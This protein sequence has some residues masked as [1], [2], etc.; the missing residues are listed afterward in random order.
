MTEQD[1]IITAKELCDAFKNDRMSA[2]KGYLN[3]TITVKGIV[4]Y[5]GP[6]EYTLPSVELSEEKEG[7]CR[8]LCVFPFIDYPKLRKAS[9]G[10]EAIIT[11][12]VHVFHNGNVIVMKK[13][14]I[15]EQV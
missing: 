9:K 14:K 12:E 4:I 3:K 8:V 6:D 5:I 15:L 7:N 13:C 1:S 2:E 11:G 10:K